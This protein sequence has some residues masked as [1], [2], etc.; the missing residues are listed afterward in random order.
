MSDLTTAYLAPEGYETPLREELAAK[1]ADIL[2]RRGR[3]FGVSGPRIHAAWAQNV[4][5][6]PEFISITSIGGGIKAL[7][8][9]QR[10]W[11]LLPDAL[12]RRASLIQQGLPAVA[13]RPFVFGTPAPVSPMGGWMLWDA[14]TILASSECSSSFPHG[15]IHFAENTVDPPSRAYLKL[16]EVFT[17][18]GRHPGPGDLCLDLGSAPGGWT[19]V[20]ATLGAHVFS[21]DK[22]PLAPHVESMPLVNH[23]ARSSAF[24][25]DPTGV[26]KVDWL[27]CDVVCYPSRL[28]D[29]VTR[30]IS[31]NTCCNFVCTIKFQKETDH[32]TS[33]CFENIEKSSLIHLY[34]NKH[35]L[36]WIR[37]G[38]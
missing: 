32:E 26:G 3:L 24:G 16:W 36:T 9:K 27:F 37:F 38:V 33:L 34:Q 22:A 25:L 1:G 30:W 2:W 14:N 23:C 15:E 29:F 21:V 19:W 13:R 11:A 28:L 4:W 12:Y 31:H 18:T 7:R 35:E 5:L 8:D 20:L 17:L 10:N 6:N